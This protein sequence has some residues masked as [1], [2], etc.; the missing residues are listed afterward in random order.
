ME[1]QT[2]SQVSKLFSISTRT[3]RYYEQIGVI[4]PAYK[5]LIKIKPDIRFFGFDCSAGKTGI[6]EG[7]YKYQ[8]WVS[9]PNN[10]SS[11]ASC[12]L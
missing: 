6:N 7:S 8:A 12:I 10:M 9:I 4:C 3:L 5:D 2:I 11:G 1:L